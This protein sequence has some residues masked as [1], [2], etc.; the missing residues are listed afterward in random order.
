MNQ[1]ANANRRVSYG[2]PRARQ[3]GI[4]AAIVSIAFRAVVRFQHMAASFIAICKLPRPVA[5]V[6]A[7]QILLGWCLPDVRIRAVAM[8]R[9]RFFATSLPGRW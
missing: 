8:G 5:T 7:A 9:A 6:S 4:S 1:F 2:P 3:L